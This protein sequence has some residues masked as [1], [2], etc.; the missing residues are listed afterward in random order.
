MTIIKN[1]VRAAQR[2]REAFRTW[3]TGRKDPNDT[4]VGALLRTSTKTG[5]AGALT[6]GAITF[7]SEQFPVL[8]PYLSDPTIAAGIAVLV[9]TVVARLSKTPVAVGKL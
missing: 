3:N 5:S 7:L 9:A 8:E 4:G 1:P 2:A 6:V